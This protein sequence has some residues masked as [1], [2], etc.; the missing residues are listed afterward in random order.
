MEV[1]V[2]KFIEREAKIIGPLSFK[3]FLYLL[4]PGVACFVLYFVMAKKSFFQ[5]VMISALLMGGGIAVGF[6]KIKG[7]PVLVFLKNFFSFS[8]SSKVFIWRKKILPP[9][10]QKIRPPEEKK[11]DESELKVIS[12][13][14]LHKL[15]T[16]VETR[17]K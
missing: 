6:V 15:S 16:I 5:Y 17:K 7:Q 3:Q 12:R 9:K 10:M 1:T 11:E 14:N 13:G 4:V 2:P 8:L